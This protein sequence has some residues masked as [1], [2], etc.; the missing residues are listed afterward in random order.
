MYNWQNTQLYDNSAFNLATTLAGLTPL[1]STSTFDQLSN[2]HA[3][4]LSYL[5]SSH[6]VQSH[7]QNQNLPTLKHQTD[8]NG[9]ITKSIPYSKYKNTIEQRRKEQNSTLTLNHHSQERIS[10]QE[11]TSPLIQRRQSKLKLAQQ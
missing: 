5:K 1:G 10:K 2:T 4:V 11:D 6:Y 3:V 9:G 7:Q 8:R